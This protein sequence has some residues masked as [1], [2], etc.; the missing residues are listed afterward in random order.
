MPFITALMPNS[1]TPVEIWVPQPPRRT[2]T[3]APLDFSRELRMSLGVGG[4]AALPLGLARRARRA[5]VPGGP[6]LPGNLERPGCP[7]QARAGCG[8]LCRAE[9]GTVYIVCARLVGA[10]V[11]DPRPSAHGWRPRHSPRAPAPGLPRWRQ[12]RG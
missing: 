7:T 2:A 8:D 11:T 1:R 4:K 6:D 5:R 12:C 9:G 10:A 3:H